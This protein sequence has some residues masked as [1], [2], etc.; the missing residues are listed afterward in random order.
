[1]RNKRTSTASALAAIAVATGSLLVP[2]AAH[3]VY[4]AA[5]SA[6]VCGM[7]DT[8]PLD[9]VYDSDGGS[10]V[11]SASGSIGHGGVTEDWLSYPG[12]PFAGSGS[13]TGALAT[14]RMAVSAVATGHG[15]AEGEVTVRDTLTFS[16]LAT[17]SNVIHFELTVTGTTSWDPPPGVTLPGGFGSGSASMVITRSSN[18]LANTSATFK[19]TDKTIARTLVLDYAV[20][21]SAPT[22][23]FT[24]SLAARIDVAQLGLGRPVGS[25]SMDLSKTAYLSVAL[26]AGVTMTSS[27]GVFLTQPIP[28]PETWAMLLA[29]LGVLG[30]VRRR[31]S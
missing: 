16:G 12:G 29:G 7:A 5:G 22:F 31:R 1:M 24:T 27:S 10:S 14:G 4:L 17:G 25:A 6:K 13:F 11:A 19:V 8:Q 28:E 20:T 18:V 15:R 23:D 21:R 9:C 3:A 2:A 30:V 26:P